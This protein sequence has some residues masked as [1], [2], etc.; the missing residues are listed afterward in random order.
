MLATALLLSLSASAKP[1]EYTAVRI[2]LHQATGLC[3]GEELQLD[4]WGTDASGKENRIKAGAWKQLQVEWDVAAVG[5]KGALAMPADPRKAWG[6]PGSLVVQLAA[7]PAVRAEAALPMRFDCRVEVNVSGED[8]RAGERGAAGASGVDADGGDAQDGGDGGDG[9]DGHDAEVRVVLVNEPVHGAPVL[10]VEVKDLQDGHAVFA[11]ISPDDGEIGISANGGTGGPGGTGG[12]GGDAASNHRGGKGG[13][14]GDGG[15]GGRGGRIALIVDPGAAGRTAAIR[16]FNSGG[17]GGQPGLPGDPGAAYQG[18][19]GDE[20]HAGHAGQSGP[21]GPTPE[22]RS[23][24]L[25]PIW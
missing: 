6:K 13:D 4:L 25:A 7:D 15:R 3:P 8:G 19:A 14:G 21:A 9:A 23:E 2:D 10:Q 24:P 18:T 20:G 12:R 17:P 1:K 22:P 11:A 16:L 5:G